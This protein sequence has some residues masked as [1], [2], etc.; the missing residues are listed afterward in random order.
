MPLRSHG[1]AAWSAKGGFTTVKTSY[2]KRRHRLIRLET[3]HQ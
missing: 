3:K 1:P 2:I